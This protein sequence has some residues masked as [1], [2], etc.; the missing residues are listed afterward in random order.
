MKNVAFSFK[1]LNSIVITFLFFSVCALGQGTVENIIIS[2]LCD[3]HND[4][5]T[6]RF[7]EIYNAGTGTV[8]LTGW[9]LTAVG[10]GVVIYTWNL[11][12]DILPGE[13][14]T[15]GD[16]NNTNFV[17]DYT[18]GMAGDKITVDWADYNYTW[19]G[20]ENDGAA[21]YDASKAIVD[22]ASTHGNFE[23]AVS[24]RLPSIGT[25]NTTFSSGEWGNN[26][27]DDA[28]NANPGYHPCEYPENQYPVVVEVFQDP[29]E[30]TS[31]DEVTI[32]ATLMDDGG[33][34]QAWVDWN[35]G[36]GKATIN[37]SNGGSGDLYT[38]VSPIP[39]Q[40]IG[41]T[42]EY[43]VIVTDIEGLS[44]YEY[45]EYTVAPP[46]PEFTN[47]EWEM[48]SDNQQ[49]W[50]TTGGSLENGFDFGLDAGNEFDYFLR[51]SG[52]TTT[53]ADIDDGLYEFIIT[54]YPEGFFEYWAEMGVHSEAT[55]EWE[56]TAW[57]MINGNDPAFYIKAENGKSTLS[58]VD[59]LEWI[60]NTTEVP[61]QI[62]KDYPS[63]NYSYQGTITGSGIQSDPIDIGMEVR[64]ETPVLVWHS[65]AFLE[66]PDN[67]GSID[68]TI[69][70]E[71]E[72]ETFT[73]T[74]GQMTAGTHFNAANVPA[75]LTI[76]IIAITD[77]TAY[78][79]LTGNADNHGDMDDIDNLEIIFLD[80]A[81]TGGNAGGVT[82]H[83][84]YDLVID[85]ID[86]A[87]IDLATVG[88]YP[89]DNYLC[90]LGEETLDITIENFGNVLI[91]AAEK[92][93]VFWEIDQYLIED[94][95]E[96]DNDLFPGEN[97]QYSFDETYDFST[98]G[99][100]DVKAYL[101]Y[102]ADQ[103]DENDML[104]GQLEHYV[105]EVDLKPDTLWLYQFELPYTIDAGDGYESY[106]WQ[107]MTT[108]TQTFDANDFGWY[109]VTVTQQNGDCE[110]KDSILINQI[111]QTD[112]DLEVW[113]PM[114]GDYYYCELT[115]DE[116][117]EMEIK[118]VGNNT[119]TTGEK[120][121]GFYI[122][123]GSPLV[124]DSVTLTS[125]LTTGESIMLTFDQTFDFSAI[126]G[127]DV[128]VYLE[129]ATDQY[130]ENDTVDLYLEHIEIDV[131]IAQ[132]DDTIYLNEWE[133]PYHLNTNQGYD[134]YY[135]ENHDGSWTSTEG[136]VYAEDYGW[137]YVSVLQG[138]D[139]E[140]EDSILLAPWP[141]LDLQI[142]EPEAGWWDLCDLE[143]GETILITV[144]NDG[145]IT[146]PSGSSIW[147]YFE[148]ND[149]GQNQQ[150]FTFD[151]DLEPDET[152]T[153]YFDQTA[154]MS[155]YGEYNF[156]VWFSFDGDQD[157][158]NNDSWGTW[159]HYE[160]WV[161]LGE[162]TTWLYPFELPY[163]LDPGDWYETYLWNDGSTEQTL[164]AADFGW[165][166]VTV[167]QQNG[168]CVAKDSIYLEQIPQSDTDIS[169]AEPQPGYNE[170]NMCEMGVMD[171]INILIQNLGV[172]A[173]P[174][175]DTIFGWYSVDG[176]P[177]VADT[178]VLTG[179]L[180]TGESIYFVFDQGYDFSA[181]QAYDLWIYINY[182]NDVYNNNDTSHL[183]INHIDNI[184]VSI[185]QGDTMFVNS[186]DFPVYLSVDDIYEE[187]HWYDQN[188]SDHGYDPDWQAWNFGWYYI[189][190]SGGE[191]CNAKDSIFIGEIP[192]ANL[193]IISP[194]GGGY[195]TCANPGEQYPEITI[196]NVGNTTIPSGSEIYTS[197]NINGTIINETFTL[198]QDL[199]PQD[200]VDYQF[201]T[202]YDFSNYQTYYWMFYIDYEFDEFSENDTVY[203]YTDIWELTVEIDDDTVWLFPFDLPYELDPGGWYQTYEWGDG[204]TN[205]IYYAPDFG[206]YYLT[207]TDMDGGCVAEDSVLL[208]QIPQSN[209]DVALSEPP[210]GEFIMDVCDVGDTDTLEFFV[211]NVGVNTIPANDTIFGW[212]SVD[213]N[214]PTPDTLVLENDFL[215]G[216]ELTLIFDQGY[217]F[218]ALQSYDL[219]IYINYEDD[220]DHNN[221][222]SHLILNHIEIDVAINQGDTIYVNDWDFPVTLSVPDEYDEYEWY[223]ENETEWNSDYYWEVW[224]Y[225][226]YFVEVESGENCHA[227][228]SVL[229]MQVPFTD[230]AVTDPEPYYYTTCMNMDE[231]ALAMR[232]MNFGNTTIP[233]GTDIYCYYK[234]NF[235][236]PVADTLTLI[237]DLGPGEEVMHSFDPTDALANFGYYDILIY[238]EYD[239]DE[240]DEND[241]V[242]IEIEHYEM[243]VDIGPDTLPIY[244]FQL[245]YYLEPEEEYDTYEWS[246]GSNDWYIEAP[247]FGWYSVTVTR[248]DGECVAEDSI[249]LEEITQ[250]DYD[251]Y[252]GFPPSGIIPVCG[253]DVELL[254]FGIMN[255]GVNAIPS[256]DTI[257]AFAEMIGDITIADTIVLTED[258]NPTDTLVYYFSEPYDFSD[259]GT[260]DFI[261]WLSYY[262]DMDSS[263]DSIVG[264]I[265]HYELTVEI[266]QGDILYIDDP[267]DFPIWLNTTDYYDE[268]Y[269]S[270]ESGSQEGFDP[271][272]EVNEHG[273]YFVEVID[274][275]GCEAYDSI[276]VTVTPYLDIAVIEPEPGYDDECGLTDNEEM[277][278]RIKNKG[279]I[280]IEAGEDI[281]MFYKIND[282]P[283]IEDTLTL[284]SDFNPDDELDFAFDMTYD[285][286]AYGIYNWSYYID[287]DG[288][289]DATNDTVMGIMEHYDLEVDLGDDTIWAYA[290]E[291]PITLEPQDWSSDYETYLWQ[292]GSTDDH[293]DATD[294]G[295]YSLTVTN[296]GGDC[297]AEDS[298]V[299]VEI[300][301]ETVDVAI[302]DPPDGF[303]YAG[304]EMEPDFHPEIYVTNVG[305]NDIPADDTIFMYFQI[306]AD[307][308]V[309]D[310]LV[311]TE[312]FASTDTIEFVFTEPMDFS[313][314]GI[315]NLTFYCNYENDV[316]ADNDTVNGVLE[317]YEMDPVEITQGD[318]IYVTP[319]DFPIYLS[320]TEMYEIYHWWNEDWSYQGGDPVFEI[321]DF[322]WYFVEAYDENYC[323]G[324]DSIHVILTPVVDIAITDPVNET[325]ETCE[326]LGSEEVVEIEITN[327]GN[328]IIPEGDT[329]FCY[330]QVN[331]DPIVADTLVL[332]ADLNPEDFIEFSFDQTIDLSA[333]I[334]Y[335][336]TIY[337]EYEGDE[338]LE[339]DIVEISLD[340][341]EL[342]VDLGPDTLELYTF[343]FPYTL[344]PGDEYE[345][346]TWQN[347]YTGPTFNANA[348][349]WYSV[350]V[351]MEDG[352]CEAW[353]SIYLEEISQ[354]NVDIMIADIWGG[355]TFTICDMGIDTIMIP[356]TNV[357]LNDIPADDT[358]YAFY[359]VNSGAIVED[360]L[361]LTSV[362]A[363][364]DTLWFTFSE[365]Y[366]FS[367][368]QS[369]DIMIWVDYDGDL[370][371][372][373]DTVTV[374]LDH[375]I[376]TVE[377]DGGDTI[378]V[379]IADLPVTLSTVDSY[380]EYFWSNATGT[381]TGNDP[382]FDATAFGWYYVTVSDFNNCEA[383]DSIYVDEAVEVENITE[384]SGT[385]ILVYPN[386]NKGKFT[387]EINTDNETD[388][389]VELYN[390]NGQLLYN[391]TDRI[392]GLSSET[393]DI[394]DFAKGVYIIKVV[395][396]DEIKIEKLIVK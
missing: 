208:E 200:D 295:T 366:D 323:S 192:M 223:N 341:Y 297:V 251:L 342:T 361:A 391:K 99:T 203:G 38:T 126:Q 138:E 135:W 393:I 87:Y 280:T 58:I 118:N 235:D 24:E 237:Q 321:N 284:Q 174:A 206:W 37:L 132:G 100:Y 104:K 110:A 10:N 197:Y 127:Y 15:C 395:A 300:T 98:P 66:H 282:D 357:G 352:N 209:I 378:F 273:W 34:Y 347:G 186:W 193:T 383:V 167:T 257:F 248:E 162:D 236:P 140:D 338:V 216:E 131:E 88:Y 12:G 213:G 65:D 1:K 6:N 270:D 390:L 72:Y 71:L 301:Q 302:T 78:I 278:L 183:I 229:I 53:N 175:D 359:Q 133:F 154:D 54:G 184:T 165:Y 86:N 238:F 374:F 161:D 260:Y 350:T 114:G 349:G 204:T 266:A 356:I 340:H 160:F 23:N 275:N 263:N 264:T 291:F 163:N 187:Y 47:M 210:A 387:L 382:T 234:I 384:T 25:P 5:G 94:S 325:G 386:P 150:E 157:G 156:H 292:D 218:S 105:L 222:T 8:S 9:T 57:S 310:T 329:I 129:Y 353:D 226:W 109:K 169:M 149:W 173:I 288:D 376:M 35:L 233:S 17:P 225:G 41:V 261:I 171:D 331:A 369:Y 107:D 379:D 124:K 190:V 250:S 189:E 46:V 205:Q 267:Q 194:Q 307:P 92:I 143:D 259:L 363:S 272:F 56:Q 219:W 394:S 28:I 232:V 322:G 11:S 392:Y 59:G 320:T 385:Q 180:A 252:A 147:G 185:N 207:V 303:D 67:N 290:F 128:R 52:N 121:Y 196:Q 22:D 247:D 312:I 43:Y 191:N 253:W 112:I 381:E 362:F 305:Q 148:I 214:P 111:S 170:V 64:D 176:A 201:G 103:N 249:Y 4:Y 168:E 199:A 230:L 113:D 317:T 152:E 316:N 89:G 339:N 85:F 304:C 141:F 344:D 18:N 21:L 212:Y 82:D 315:Y 318:T 14:R 276:L 48:S 327:K 91:P 217:D 117:I 293:Y 80:D 380:D 44:A 60:V 309:A 345:T 90:E 355:Q 123:N 49:S 198:Q 221:D 159:N 74:A 40:A 367:T 16:P 120:I 326:D 314:V 158:G 102:S 358:I 7:I 299:I 116:I 371:T 319:D 285:F 30:P 324:M 294:F 281:Y 231:T 39:A 146:I 311:L 242:N 254:P 346:Y 330:Y 137:Y 26:P 134:E 182:E 279:N 20:N 79:E 97:V 42:I 3:P 220:L 246:T 286:S 364:T 328:V 269:W 188:E 63:G 368:I 244:A 372:G 33:V 166:K 145:N 96:L 36:G 389:Q 289:E 255:V 27:V 277:E 298:V 388:I 332:A 239:Q 351:T 240:Y 31:V 108:T 115:D 151:G 287:Y 83:E 335:D 373:N 365:P 354:S 95:I 241:E 396:N 13:A 50:Q 84:K 215:P 370:D 334:L 76:E 348:E 51:L 81:F 77:T 75:G 181:Q 106:L 202:P 61:W 195:E 73:V 93:Y 377:I 29:V 136:D 153:F 172:N 224:D 45:G 360:T 62:F 227:K 245:P 283:A 139:C 337:V 274:E 130:N 211:Q 122:I 258:L 336:I 69:D 256:G 164:D 144:R 155:G 306:N 177:V 375:I 70:I 228:D 243:T 119:L 333:Y 125:D 19:N 101:E 313:T 343:Q 55:G 268:Y 262:N 178:L 179:N 296:G 32:S 68:N 308:V 271:D 265:D 2:K 142:T